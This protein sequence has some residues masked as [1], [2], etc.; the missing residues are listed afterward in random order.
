MEIDDSDFSIVRKNLNIIS[1]LILVLAFTNAE[2]DCLNF[3]GISLELDGKRLY[4][5]LFLLYA[6]FIWRYTTKV[7]LLS[8]FWVG[9]VKYYLDSE[10]GVKS[11]HNYDRYKDDLLNSND[12]LRWS[13]EN[14]PQ[15]RLVTT[16]IIRSS[17]TALRNLKL[18]LTFYRAKKIREDDFPN[19][20]VDQEIEVSRRFIFRTI[21]IYCIKY[22]KFGDYLFPFIPI[23]INLIF[24][25][26][27]REWQG[28][29]FSLFS[30]PGR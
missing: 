25:F 17:N 22:D 13:V 21:L 12:Q 10:A 2:I 15:F 1:V 23:A 3:L 7:P 27:K 26:T 18:M 14:D 30:L 5:F 6:Y 4:V 16:T 24:F 9:L 11:I 29:I 20:T 8:E 28:S 19:F